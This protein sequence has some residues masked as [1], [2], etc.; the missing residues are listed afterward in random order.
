[1]AVVDVTARAIE[2]KNEEED[3]ALKKRKQTQRRLKDQRE[4]L[5][6]S[7][8]L[9]RAFEIELASTFATNRISATLPLLLLA[10]LPS[11]TAA[12]WSDPKRMLIW[13]GIVMLAIGAYY[14]VCRAFLKSADQAIDLQSWHYG[15]LGAE[16]FLT[17]TWAAIPFIAGSPPT[18]SARLVLVFSL[19]LFSA[20]SVIMS[21]T[22]R[23]IV[24]ANVLGVLLGIMKILNFNG[25]LK[26]NVPLFMLVLCGMVFS[27]LLAT[28]LNRAQLVGLIFRA[29]KDDLIGELETE[30]SRSDEARKRAEDANLAK[31]R[32]LATMSHELRTP[33][34]AILGFSEVMKS[35][36]FGPHQIPQ[37]KE[38]S[39][40][41]HTS[42]EH[43]LSLINEVL[44]LSRIEAGRYALQEEAVDLVGLVDDCVHMLDIRARKREL[45]IRTAFEEDL[46]RVWADERAIRQVVLNLMSNAIKFTPQGSEIYVKVGWTAKGGQYVA[47]RDN[48][49]GIPE[50]EIPL[51]METFGRG[52]Q[53][54]KSAE[55]GSGLGLPIVKG[56]VELHGGHFIL[57]SKV[58]EGTEV[59][60]TFP[61]QRVMEALGKVENRKRRS[62]ET[63]E[64]A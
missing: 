50:D 27:F 56:L 38:Y 32:F 13:Y 11:V 28:Q 36:L 10:L 4:R 31:S 34:N 51:V 18:E 8:G 20:V 6:S 19:I 39:T 48:G 29:E 23:I 33:L 54:H 5:T 2:R 49:V 53:A 9:S 46:P 44:D 62:A 43:L 52:S 21:A 1:M 40:D 17:L 63:N 7:V 22:M 60:A 24:V 37:Y 55:P 64:A 25:G 26:A 45:K 42:G 12:G 14:A 3:L 59:I 58:R 35:E 47:I 61:A 41:I 16:A 15:F 30:K 57:R